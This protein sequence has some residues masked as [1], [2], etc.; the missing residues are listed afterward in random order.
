MSICILCNR[1]KLT[2]YAS[3]FRESFGMSHMKAFALNELKAYVIISQTVNK[4][5]FV[6][7]N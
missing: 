2:Y 5:E 1:Q 6:E 7:A 3:I 4:S